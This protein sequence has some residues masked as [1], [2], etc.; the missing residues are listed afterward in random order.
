MLRPEAHVLADDA[1][2][3]EGEDVSPSPDDAFTHELIAD[4]PYGREG[5][6]DAHGVLPAGTP[7]VLTVEGPDHFRVVDGRGVSVEVL[8]SNLRSLPQ[9][10]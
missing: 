7:V 1:V 8:R 2:L 5:G 4:V 3:P 9:R 6:L 10:P